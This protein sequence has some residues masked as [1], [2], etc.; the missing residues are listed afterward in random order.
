MT[1]NKNSA[2]K[3]QGTVIGIVNVTDVY[4]SLAWREGVPGIYRLRAQCEDTYM[5]S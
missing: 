5:Q 1:R 3:P 4:N 2:G